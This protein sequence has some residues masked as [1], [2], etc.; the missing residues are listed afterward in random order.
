MIMEKRDYYEVLGVPR[1]ADD[2]ALKSAYRQLARSLHPDRNPDDPR[3]EEGFKEAAEAYQVL[4]DPQKR[5]AYDRFGHAGLEGHGFVDPSDMFSGL[6]DMLGDLFGGFR[7]RRPDAPRQG[8]NVH[9]VL[10]LDLAEAIEGVSKELELRHPSPCEPCQGTG[11]EGAAMDRCPRC[12]GIGRLAVRRGGF[13]VQVD[14]P[15]CHGMGRTAK[16]RCPECAGTGEATVDR[17]VSVDVPAGVAH[18]DTL[19]VR[20]EGQA[21]TRGGPSG[22]LLVE[23]HVAP[24]PHFQRDGDHLVHRLHLSFPQAALGARVKVP[25]LREGDAGHELAVPPGVQPGETLMI[26]GAGA[27][28]ARGRGR[29]AILCVVQVEVPKEL[30]PKAKELIQALADTFGG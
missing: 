22:H 3:A 16:S 19:R 12:N 26:E 21:G 18:G 25:G 20:G 28:S 13:V 27:P 9:T 23:I 2:K 7:R 4:A 24:H 17:R 30:S 29:G 11:A 8:S 1:N 10:R 14:C 15:D 6:Q 5:A